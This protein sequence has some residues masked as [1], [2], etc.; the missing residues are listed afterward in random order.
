MEE[1]VGFTQ[2]QRNWLLAR[3]GQRCL[4][5]VFVKGI[6][7]RCKNTQHLQAHH[8]LPRGWALLHLPK[9]FEVNSSA[10]G[11]ILC[12][13]NHIGYRM[14]GE[15]AIYVIHRD[16]E[17]A[18]VNYSTDKSSFAK[19]KTN[20]KALNERGIPYWETRWDWMFNRLAKRNNLLYAGKFPN[21][22]YPMNGRRGNTGRLIG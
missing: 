12:R 18:R 22:L 6:W 10:N 17:L 20:R 14:N 15:D 7:Q 8:I 21:D 4:F 16:T 11:I 19:M 2:N 13:E 3:D 9:D 1:V 5:Y